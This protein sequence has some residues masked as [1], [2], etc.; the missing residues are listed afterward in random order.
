MARNQVFNLKSIGKISDLELSF[1]EQLASCVRDC[2]ERPGLS[3]T[4]EVTLKVRL[5]PYVEDPDEV[6]VECEVSSKVPTRK[7]DKYHMLITTQ[8]GLKFQPDAPLSPDQNTLDFEGKEEEE[9]E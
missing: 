1:D 9:E 3:R 7:I 8:G 6:D 4:R 2:M 5:T